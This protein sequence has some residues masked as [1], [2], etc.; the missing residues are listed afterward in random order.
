MA[1]CYAEWLQRHDR[2]LMTYEGWIQHLIQ[3][4]TVDGGLRSIR[5]Q[6]HSARL[7]I[8][9]DLAGF[10]FEQ[11]KVD[12]RQVGIFATTEFAER[13]E[14]IVLIGGTG[15]GKTRLANALGV[16]AIAR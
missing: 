6:M 16:E 9:R 10:D 2:R 11:S 5:Y 12:R 3:A 13:A 7:P 4:E 15:I 14:N 8:H 1:G